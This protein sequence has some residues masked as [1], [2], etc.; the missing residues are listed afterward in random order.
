MPHLSFH[1][2]K[3]KI[4]PMNGLRMG[5]CI[6]DGDVPLIMDRSVKTCH[7]EDV[8]HLPFGRL[9]GVLFSFTSFNSPCC[10]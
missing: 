2:G 7:G 4:H 9:L 8:A 1:I 10:S 6:R 3:E 5:E